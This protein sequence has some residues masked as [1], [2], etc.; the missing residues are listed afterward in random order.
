MIVTVSDGKGGTAPVS[1]MWTVTAPPA[2]VNPNSVPCNGAKCKVRVAW[3]A[4]LTANCTNTATIVVAR[5]LVRIRPRDLNLRGTADSRSERATK[6]KMAA[7]IA[8]IPPGATG[9]KDE[10]YR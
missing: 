6:V 1:F 4:N 9:N 5:K 3:D 7:G 8:N 2:I 10:T